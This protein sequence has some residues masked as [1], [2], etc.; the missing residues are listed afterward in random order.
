[1]KGRVFC[2]HG[3]R[4][5]AARQET[6]KH[7]LLTLGGTFTVLLGLRDPSPNYTRQIQIRF[8]AIRSVSALLAGAKSKPSIPLSAREVALVK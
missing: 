3:A 5:S 1:M 8:G 4:S 7:R 6:R 2:P